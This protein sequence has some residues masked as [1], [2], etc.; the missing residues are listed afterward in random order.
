MIA[1]PLVVAAAIVDSLTRPTRLLGARRSAPKSLAGQWE[2]A[3]GK[4]EPGE[5][6]RDALRREIAE[7]LGV[8][9][10][11]GA[12]VPAPDGADWPIANGHRM[13]VWLVEM[14]GEPEPLEDHDELR[15]LPIAGAHDAVP[16]LA[17][18]LPIVAAVQ[19]L[20]VG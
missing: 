13:R 16:W 17:P 8:R 14:E 6:V 10:R 1:T 11:I 2:F 18:D 19:G 15:W 7:E 20:V 12:P 3:G 9:I 5:D 4:V